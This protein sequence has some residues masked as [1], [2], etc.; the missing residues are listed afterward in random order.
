[1]VTTSLVIVGF[2]KCVVPKP[3]SPSVIVPIIR[4][5]GIRL[6]MTDRCVGLLMVAKTF[7]TVVVISIRGLAVRLAS[8]SSFNLSVRSFTFIRATVRR[9]CWLQWLVRIL[10][11]GVRNSTGVNRVVIIRFST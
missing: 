8:M 10:V 2:S 7:R 1:M 6:E 5:V 3:V 11:Y 9:W 4:L